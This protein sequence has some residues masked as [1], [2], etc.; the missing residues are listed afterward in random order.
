MKFRF[1]IAMLVLCAAL[2]CKKE[3]IIK[4]DALVPQALGALTAKQDFPFLY[5]P[6]FQ[7]MDQNSF[8]ISNQPSWMSIDSATGRISGTPTESAKLS[9]IIVT[10]AGPS[11]EK[12]ASFDVE[13]SGDSFTQHQWALENSGQTAFAANAGLAGKDIKA[14]EAHRFGAFGSGVTVMVSDE[15]L[16]LSHED[17]APNVAAGKSKNYLLPDPFFGD[18]IK[19][20]TTNGNHGTAVAGII[21]AK[22][23]NGIGVRGVAPEAKIAGTNYLTAALDPKVDQTLIEVDQ[24]SDSDAPTARYDAFNY[25]YGYGQL[26][27]IPIANTLVNQLIYG[28][29]NQRA[30]KGSLYVKSAG[31]SYVVGVQGLDGGG[32]TVVVARSLSANHE[33]DNAVPWM[34][35]VGALNAKGTH[36]SYSS[37]GANVFVSAPGG[38]FGDDD[39]AIVTTDEAGCSNGYSKSSSKT[40]AFEGGGGGNASCNYVSGFNGTSSAAPHVTGTVAL[41][42]S[43]NPN[44]GWRDVR[45]LL[46]TTAKQ[47]D[48]TQAPI[49]LAVNG[50]NVVMEDA[51]VTNAAGFK[52][53]PRYGLG[54]IDA[55][56]AV[57]AAAGYVSTFGPLKQTVTKSNTC[58][59]TEFCANDVWLFNNTTAQVIPDNNATG[60]N[61]TINV[62]SN[63]KI[64]SIQIKVT[65]TTQ[66]NG[67]IGLRLTSP[68]G[69]VVNVL[70]PRGAMFD[71]GFTDQ[72]MLSNAYYGENSSGNWTLKVFD[73]QPQTN[74]GGGTGNGQLVRWSINVI[75]R[76]P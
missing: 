9:G 75:G 37:A 11:G 72:V 13:V 49:M 61:S 15:G 59:E 76:D 45:H 42:L 51:W 71:S 41:M 27:L 24:A 17:L 33:E 54:S 30:G 29:T 18:P 64:E 20:N 53:N 44:L 60:I 22:G 58:P 14:K 69:T 12:K 68:S 50:T 23:W 1:L 21:A 19:Q 3:T 66:R 36:S 55:N 57:R 52:F 34:T 28:V 48:P 73:S 31:N 32:K 46:A 16:Q 2:G 65:I 74:F 38:E 63:F 62:T 40:N 25:S 5:Q 70:N 35:V 67:D 39:P 7:A 56:A 10:A 4:G 26:A 6:T 8:S 43:V 47:P